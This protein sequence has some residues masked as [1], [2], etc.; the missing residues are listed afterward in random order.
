MHSEAASHAIH[1]TA[2]AIGGEALLICGPSRSGKSR[3][4]VALIARASPSRPI[5]LIGDDRILLH[6]EGGRLVARPHPRTA[7]FLERRGLGFVAM[8]WIALAEVGG[9]VDLEHPSDKVLQGAED[10]RLTGLPHLEISQPR[11]ADLRADVV[12]VWWAARD[13]A[14]APHPAGKADA[15]VSV[16]RKRL[17]LVRE[18]R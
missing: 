3:L 8:P 4:A 7:G 15:T 18:T 5:T 14:K 16:V 2:V 9:I 1:A 11:D 13:A 10:G 12:L 17:E 6:R